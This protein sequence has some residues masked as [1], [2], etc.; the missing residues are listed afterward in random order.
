MRRANVGCFVRFRGGKM[1]SPDIVANLQA[2]FEM[3]LHFAVACGAVDDAERERLLCRCW[4]FSFCFHPAWFGPS[5]VIAVSVRW[6]YAEDRAPV[7]E[8]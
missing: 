3:Y 6:L 5:C 8:R 2:G 1:A 7:W 4:V